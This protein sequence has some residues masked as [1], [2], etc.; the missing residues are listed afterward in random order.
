MMTL[1]RFFLTALGCSLS[2]CATMD[3]PSRNAPFEPLRDHYGLIAQGDQTIGGADFSQLSSITP[4]IAVD[5][6][7]KDAYND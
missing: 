4:L 1:R 6:L 5:V 7:G 2:A 3:T